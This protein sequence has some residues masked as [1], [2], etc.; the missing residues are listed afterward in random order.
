NGWGAWGTV[1]PTAIHLSTAN[2]QN[3][4]YVLGNETQIWEHNKRYQ[5]LIK[6][7]DK[8]G[9]VQTSFVVGQSSNAFRYDT[10]F[11]TTTVVVPPS[12]LN[13]YNGSTKPIPLVSGTAVDETLGSRVLNVQYSI[14]E[15]T[16]SLYWLPSASTFSSVSEQF[17]NMFFTEPNVWYSTRPALQD[18]YQ[19]S[20][21][22]Q[23]TDRAGNA[24]PLRTPNAFV[25]DVSSPTTQITNP[26]NGLHTS[27]SVMVTGTVGDNTGLAGV[28]AVELAIQ[29]DTG[30]WYSGTSKTFDATEETF[31]AAVPTDGFQT[32]FATG[33]PWVTDHVYSIK[34][35]ATDKAT[36][37]QQ[38]FT[39][40][41]STLTFTY[42]NK[43]P[44]SR[45]TFPDG[46]QVRSTISQ[47]EGTASDTKAG[48]KLVYASIGQIAGQTTSY[49]NGSGFDAATE[50]FNLATYEL[51]ASTWVYTPV[52]PYASGSRYLF[53]CFAIDK[54][55][56]PETTLSAQIAAYYDVTKPTAAITTPAHMSYRSG[57]GSESDP[58]EGSAYD[59]TAGLD[60]FVNDGVQVRLYEYGGQWWGGTTFNQADGN[61]AWRKGNA[62]TPAA[63]QYSD[64]NLTGQL[65]SGT[66]Y[67]VQV[68]AR[69]T[70]VPYNSGP[71]TNGTD[72]N[73]TLSVD[74]VSF[75]ADKIAPA[76]LLILPVPGATTYT[77]ALPTI[78]GTSNDSVSKI[79]AAGQVTVGIKEIAP[80]GNWWS[81]DSTFSATSEQFH[82]VTSLL[83]TNSTWTLT[84]PPFRHGYG[85]RVLVKASDNVVPTPNTEATASL[86]SATFVYDVEYPTATVTSPANGAVICS[87]TSV[88]GSTVEQFK[89]SGVYITMKDNV[90]GKWWDQSGSTFS[91]TDGEKIFYL[92]TP[93][94]PGI[95]TTWS[96]SVDQSKFQTG[97]GYTVSYY[98]LDQAGNQQPDASSGFTWDKTDPTSAVVEPANGAFIKQGGFV[99]VTGW[100]DD[101]NDISKVEISIQRVD[102]DKW[103][104]YQGASGDWETSAGAIYLPTPAT[105]NPPP[106][107]HRIW[108]QTAELPPDEKLLNPSDGTQFRIRVRATDKPGN[109]QQTIGD[110][111]IFRYD[112]TPPNVAIQF[113]S[114]TSQYASVP[115]LSGTAQDLFN[116]KQVEIRLKNGSNEYWKFGQGY[117]SEMDTWN[118][119]TGSSA[120]NSVVN[121]TF[122]NLPTWEQQ[123][124]VL[125]VRARDE[126]GNYTATYSTVTFYYDSEAPVVVTTTPVTGGTYK[127]MPG[128]YGTAQDGNSPRDI[129]EIRVKIY[130]VTGGATSYWNAGSSTWSVL[131]SQGWGLVDP[132]TKIAGSLWRWDLTHTNFTNDPLTWTTNTTYYILAKALDKAGNTGTE[133]ST[134]TFV[135]DNLPPGSSPTHP[136]N[137]RA[138]KPT[139]LS[140]IS[141]TAVDETSPLENVK[142]SVKDENA[143]GGAKYF[144]GTTFGSDV[145]MFWSVTELFP[146]SWTFA[147]GGL[148]FVDDHHY[149]IKSSAA[150]TIGNIETPGS[151]NRILVD[152][153]KPLSGVVDPENGVTYTPDKTIY[154][155]AADT[156]FTSGI[157]G[158][159]SGVRKTLGWHQ[160]KAQVL[161]VKYDN[162]GAWGAGPLAYGSWGGS[163]YFWDGSTWTLT[164]E[165][166]KWMDCGPIN[167]AGV[168]TYTTISNHW[169]K[170]KFY[171]VWVRAIDNAGNTQT[172]VANGPKIQI[173]AEA[174]N[175]V[176]TGLTSGQTAGFDNTVTV[177]AKDQE[178]FRATAYQGWVVFSAPGGHEIPD[179]DDTVDDIHGLPKTYKFT[180]TDAG[181]HTFTGLVRFRLIGQ[182]QLR[183]EDSV[184]SGVF[185]IQ[186]N[187]QVN[188]ATTERL[189][190]ILSSQT[191]VAG[192]APDPDGNGRDGNPT[193]KTAGNSIVTNIL[194]V[195]KYWNIN[196]GSSPVANIG[197][198]DPY[199]VDPGTY[200]LQNGSA[201]INVVMTTAGN[202]TVTASGAGT[203]NESNIVTINPKGAD[204]VLA[205][206]PGQTRVQG[207]NK[208]GGSYGPYYGK[209]GEVSQI[210]AGANMQ[211]NVYSVDEYYN[212]NAGGNKDVFFSL[213]NNYDTTVSSRT[214]VSGT[215]GM[216]LVPVTA[217]SQVVKATAAYANPQYISENFTVYPDTVT[218]HFRIQLV[219]SG[220]TP[221]AG[222]PPYEQQ[223]GGKTGLPAV[224]YTG[225]GATV[226]VRLVDRYYNLIPE[227]P[228]MPLVTLNT[229][230]PN[231]GT[232]G[233]DGKQVSLENGVGQS[234]VTFVTQNNSE[235]ATSNPARDG[236]GWQV[237]TTNNRGYW[238]DTSTNVVTWPNDVVKLRLIA[239]NQVAKEGSDPAGTGK[240]NSPNVGQAGAT[241]ALTVQAVDAYWNRNFGR[242]PAHKTKTGHQVDVE[243]NDPYAVNHATISMVDGEATFPNFA[244]RLAQDNFILWA[245]DVD[246][247]VTVASQT[248]T[249]VAVSANEAKHLQI[250]MPGE[251]AVPGKTPYGGD[252]TGGK[253]G[254]PDPVT[255]GNAI[256]SGGVEVRLT[257]DYWNPVET[258]ALPWVVLSA[259]EQPLDKYAL[260]PSS[261]QMSLAVY[262]YR[263]VF[264]STV[265]FRTAGVL[266]HRLRATGVDI[267]TYTSLNSPYFTVAPNALN[268]MQILMTGETADPGRW[269]NYAASP[270][271]L[272]G[273]YGEP[274]R[275]G[276]N[277]NGVQ[278]LWA[279][280]EYNV[281]VKGVD[282]YY[283]VVST[284]AA[285]SV[286]STDPNGTPNNV[287]PLTRS[288]INGT[289]SF[290]AKFLTAQ[291]ADGDPVQR[292][293]TATSGSLNPDSTPNMWVD[294]STSTRILVIFPGQTAAPGTSRGKTGSINDATAGED[295]AI[296]V[297]L[298]DNYFNAVGNPDSPVY[299]RLTTTDPYDAAQEDHIINMGV[300]NYEVTYTTHQ[301]IT[302]SSPGWMVSVSTYS[303]SYYVPE[304]TG[305]VKVNS[306]TN[307]GNNHYLLVLLP[308]QTYVQG[309]TSSPAGRSG[310]PDFTTLLGSTIPKAGDN[311]PVTI[312]AVDRFYN[313]VYDTDNP[314]VRVWMD[315]FLFSTFSA[316]QFS[317]T[318]GSAT[319]NVTVKRS[320]N[321]ASLS[322]AEVA[323]PEG[324]E[325]ST[326]ASSTFSVKTNAATRL[327]VLLPGET[328]IP[329][330]SS[331]KTG[332]PD[333]D[334]NNSANGDGIGGNIDDFVAGNQYIATV[335]AT[336]EFYNLVAAA[337]AKVDLT[338][339]DA[340][341]TPTNVSQ[342]LIGGV[343]TYNI[344][345]FTASTTGWRVNVSTSLGDL[346]ASTH[347]ALAVVRASTPTKLLLTVPGESPDPGDVAN[348][349]KSGSLASAPA[350]T[351]TAGNIWVATASAVDNWYNTNASATGDVW[352]ET[353]GDPYD[354]DGTTLVLVNGTTSFFIQM[355]KAGSQS[356]TVYHAGGGYSSATVTGI[357]I[358]AGTAEKV[359]VI[360]PGE[361]YRPGKTSGTGGKED[362]D[363]PSARKAGEQ[364]DVTVYATDANWNLADSDLE[365]NLSAASDPNPSGVGNLTLVDGATTYKVT[366]YKAVNYNGF[367]QQL[368][369]TVAGLADPNYTTPN[370]KVYPDTTGARKVR[371]L[372]PGESAAPGTTAGKDGSP[373][374]SATDGHFIVGIPSTITVQGTDSWGNI[375]NVSSTIALTTDDP[376]DTPV[377][378]N[379]VLT[380]GTS[381]F[382]HTFVTERTSDVDEVTSP[383]VTTITGSTNGFTTQ[384]VTIAV[385]DE[386]RDRYL[387][388]LI[389]GESPAPGT[390]VWP[391]GGKTGQP[392]GDPVTGPIDNFY[393]G[394]ITTV[395]VRTVDRYFN[396][397]EYPSLG[398]P[399]IEIRATDPY[400]TNPLVSGAPMSKGVLTSNITLR[401]KN[402]TTGWLAVASGSAGGYLFSHSTSAAIKVDAGPL[403]RLQILVPGE[404]PVQGSDTGK[405]GVSSTQI[406]GVQFNVPIGNIR[407]V[408][409]YYN[410]VSTNGNVTVTMRD[411]FGTPQSQ[412][413]SL[414]AGENASPVPI[415]LNITTDTFS[416]QELYVSGL[417]LAKSTS[418]AIPVRPNNPHQL[419]LL[420][421]GETAVPGSSTGKTGN[422]DQVAAGDDYTVTVNLVD[423]KYNKVPQPTQPTVK[424]ETV[425]LYAFP[426]L[427]ANAG[428]APGTA[429]ADFVLKFKRANSSPGWIVRA[430]TVAGSALPTVIK[431]ESP[432]VVVIATTTDR[433]QLV[434]PGETAVPGSTAGGARGIYG[435]A[436][437]T[438]AG[439]DYPV[440]VNLTDRF[441][442]IKTDYSPQVQIE[443]TDT[444]DVHPGTRTLLSGTTSY[445]VKFYT[446]PGPWTINASTTPAHI[447]PPIQNFV[448]GNVTVNPGPAAKLQVLVPGET[449][450]PGKPP[451]DSGELGGKSGAPDSDPGTGGNQ[452]FTAGTGF[453]VTVNLVDQYFNKSNT[454]NTFVKLSAN[455]PFDTIESLGSKQTGT[456]G[457]PS[458]RIT[459]TGVK[460]VTRNTTPGWQIT[461]STASGDNYAVGLSTW[462]PTQSGA[463]EK[464]LVL[465]PGEASE[466]GN[467]IG[468]S[469]D[470]PDPNLTVGS[471][472]TVTVRAVDENYNIVTTTDAV[473]AITFI[474]NADASQDDAFSQPTRPAAKPLTAGVTTFDLFLVTAENKQTVIIATAPYLSNGFSGVISP[475][476]G[477][478]ERY[479][480]LLPGETAVPGSY[481]GNARGMQGL[482]DI[483]GNNGDGAEPFISGTPFNVTLRA[484][485]PYWNKTTAIPD[486]MQLTSTDNNDSPDPRNITLTAGA[487]TVAWTM[488][489]ANTNN[490]WTMTVDDGPGAFMA[491]TSTW[492]P[493]APGTA[494]KLQIIL[495]GEVAAPGTGTGK[496]AALPTDWM[497]GVSSL[498][499]VNVVD[500]NWNVVPDA[501]LS[502]KLFNNT[503]MYASSQ[504]LSL[505]DGTTTFN[506]VLYTATA[507]STLTV[508][509]VSGQ[510]LDFPSANS[511]PFKIDHNQ[512]SRLLVLAPGESAV[513]GK[514]PYDGT[515]GKTGQPDY[516]ANPVNGVTNFPAGSTFTITVLE[517]DNYYNLV[518]DS[519][520][521]QLVTQDPFDPSPAAQPLTN[522]STT[523]IIYMHTK[524]T[525]PGWTVTVSTT[526]D[527]ATELLP[528][529]TPAIP[530]TF[531]SPKK[532]QLLLPGETA[533]PGSTAGGAK[534]KMDMPNHTYAGSRYNVQVRLTDNYYN[535]VTGVS[536][537]TVRLT[538]TDP[539]DDENAYFGGN[540]QSLTPATG[541]ATFG[542]YFNT[543]SSWTLTASDNQY[544]NLYE[545][546]TSTQ[547]FIYP[548][549]YDRMLIVLPGETYTPGK[550]TPLPLGRT[551]TPTAKTVGENINTRII[552]TDSYYNKVAT[553]S[554][555]VSVWTDDPYDTH[556]G[557]FSITNG[558]ITVSTVNLRMARSATIVSATDIDGDPTAMG[559]ANSASFFVAH[560]TASKIQLVFPGE[561]A[562]PGNADLTKGVLGSPGVAPAGENIPVEVRLC[563]NFWNLATATS[564]IRF[565]S[566][567]PSDQSTGP[568]VGIGKDPYDYNLITTSATVYFPLITL[569]DT[570]WTLTATDMDA[571][572]APFN[573]PFTEFTSQPINVI[574]GTAKKLI[575]AM[576]GESLDPGTQVGRKGTVKVSTAGIQMDIEVYVT[577]IFSNVVTVPPATSG[578]N[579]GDIRIS[580]QL[581][582]DPYYTTTGSTKAVVANTGKSVFQMTLVRAG[583][584]TIVADDITQ[585]HGLPWT[586]SPSSI[587]TVNPNTAKHLL[588]LM[589]GEVPTPGSGTPGKTANPTNRVAGATFTVTVQIV[590][591]YFNSQAVHVD[592]RIRVET[593]DLYDTHP[594][595]A[596]YVNGQSTDQFIVRLRTAGSQHT[597]WAADT[598]LDNGGVTWTTS[599]CPRSGAFTVDPS[600]AS[601]FLVLFEGESHLPGSATGKTGS[602]TNQVAGESFEVDVRLTDEQFNWM[603]SSGM[604]KVR[605]VSNDPLEEYA[606]ANPNQLS[607][608]ERIFTM[609][610]KTAQTNFSVTASTT[611]DTPSGTQ[612]IKS[613]SASGMR[614][615][616]G[617]AHHL[618][619][620]N[621]PTSSKAAGDPFN[622][623]I[624]AYDQ[625]QNLL[626]T[627]PNLYLGTIVFSAQ[628][629]A[630]QEPSLPPNYTF[631]QADAGEKM[632]DGPP[633]GNFILY[634]A[635]QCWLKAYDFT[636]NDISTE[637]VE[638]GIVYSTRPYVSIIPG[639]A[640][641]Y[642]ILSPIDM[643]DGVIDNLISVA[644]G[645]TT[646]LGKTPFIAQL[647]DQFN[648]YIS[649]AGY[650]AEFTVYNVTGAT[651]TVRWKLG[652]TYN[653]ITATTTDANGQIGSSP[654][655]YYFVST[656][657]VDQAQVR[658][659]SD[660]VIGETLPIITRGGTPSKWVLI[661]PPASATAG[662]WV[663]NQFTLERRDDFNNATTEDVSNV[664]LL[665]SSAQATAHS[666]AGR[667][668]YFTNPTSQGT[669]I[670]SLRFDI[671]TSQKK[672]SLFDEMSSVPV[673]E[674]GRV[675][676]WQVR[677]EGAPLTTTTHELLVNPGA[678]ASIGVDNP[679]RTL[680]AGKISYQGNVQTFEFE[681]W[682]G[683]RNP[684]LATETIKIVF[685]STRTTSLS[686]DA[687]GFTVSSDETTL[688]EL[689]N[690]VTTYLE[691]T[692]GTYVKQFF[693]FDT[694][695]SE[696][697][698]A[699]ASSRPIIGGHAEARSWRTADHV[700]DIQP[701]WDVDNKVAII[702]DPAVFVAGATTP[703]R[704]MQLQDRY[705]NPT[706]V[707]T[708]QEDDVGKGIK[709][710][711]KSDSSGDYKFASPSSATFVSGNGVAYLALN[712]HTTPYY[713]S[714]TLAGN[715]LHTISAPP[716]R[717][718][719]VAVQTY[720]VLAEP[721]VRIVFDNPQRKLIAGS[722]ST[723]VVGI[724]SAYIRAQTRDRFNNIAPVIDDEDIDIFS[725]S[726]K[727][728]ASV[729]PGNLSSFG[730]IYGQNALPLRFSSGTAQR[731]F[732]YL[733]EITG[734]PVLTAVHQDLVLVSTTQ[735]VVITPNQANHLTIH[736]NY[737]LASPL[738]VR[739]EG[740]IN[741][742]ARDVYENPADGGMSLGENNGF[743]Y[744]GTLQLAHSGSTSNVTMS[745]DGV[746]VSTL[747]L[748]NAATGFFT[749]RDIIQESLT[750]AATDFNK[751]TINGRTGLA[752]SDGQVVTTGLVVTPADMAPEPIGPTRPAF[753]DAIG[754]ASAL[755]QGDGNT[756]DRPN[757]VSMLRLRTEV[758]PAGV[759]SYSVWK[760]L[761]VKKTGTLPAA[762][763]TQ[764]ALWRDMGSKDGVFSINVDGNGIQAGV[765]LASSTFVNIAGVYYCDFDFTATSQTLTTTYQHFFVTVRVSTKATEGASL[766]LEIE[767]SSDFTIPAAESTA[768]IAENNFP[769]KTYNSTIIKTPA[770][771]MTKVEDIAAFYADT[772]NNEV[773][774]GM[775]AAGYLRVA[776]W[777]R[778][779]EGIL[780]KIRVTRIGTC[781]DMD[782]ANARLY[783]DGL[784]GTD[785]DA[786]H[787]FQPGADTLIESS[788]VQFSTSAAILEIQPAMKIDGTTK[789]LFIVMAVADS[790]NIGSS[791]GVRIPSRTDFI[792]TDGMMVDYLVD[793]RTQS[794]PVLSGTPPITATKDHLMVDPIPMAPAAATQGEKNV[795]VV[796][797]DM[798]SDA[799]TVILK[800]LRID[801]KNSNQVNRSEDISDIKV[802][803]DLDGDLKLNA[804]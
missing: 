271:N 198:S 627:G 535:V 549:T 741:L 778:E 668:Y 604:P 382:F 731:D 50:Y 49:F 176:V 48:V 648:N 153:H 496:T 110:P 358:T 476:A 495:P 415:T 66:T 614:V 714:D 507:A 368:S 404:T 671:G 243:S 642:L 610:A 510:V 218:S 301:F 640:N 696:S 364:F 685:E 128:I 159:G 256:A 142:V 293:L 300:A 351:Y 38:V 202:Q 85:Y 601:R 331:G 155:T 657:A 717:G 482:P 654:E 655:F 645:N 18:S 738:S 370:V 417:G 306:D 676:T 127:T 75:I 245:Y 646:N 753:K 481:T 57:M 560:S 571:N 785:G 402:T 345:F 607:N 777:T 379:V 291:N 598:N 638:N 193:P 629:F 716:A 624:R 623:G 2:L 473:V 397:V 70:A 251:T 199:D 746:G 252:P 296:K 288:L 669:H 212:L 3:W 675:G 65:Q 241:Y 88:G 25:F 678:T 641:K 393:A 508:Q 730:S 781:S 135:F 8:P 725:S 699:L 414:S 412:S 426:D 515:G 458:G 342:D 443:T 673:G 794:F 672:F 800:G 219:F 260:M 553:A 174:K 581:N 154:G 621:L 793:P 491:F 258:G 559:T 661:N 643:T 17:M 26:Q 99:Q 565:T 726:S 613:G 606:T 773:P 185:G 150:D 478:T 463:L 576:P 564:T 767:T 578:S 194:A 395:T 122:S 313:R 380:N 421:P 650:G 452:P 341:V 141:G 422:P 164:G 550:V 172:T 790:A 384:N 749:M 679:K 579:T 254:T 86:S 46:T 775:A 802:Y 494:R 763:V 649:S 709:F 516:D 165:G 262:G 594:S 467:P 269:A 589:P 303:G 413:F 326:G 588:A 462:I 762:E 702:S 289:T 500:D 145:E 149:V 173:A 752:P 184:D 735:S 766:G 381:T 230:D 392:D 129:Q 590:D 323:P 87:L 485:D 592:E 531:G 329:G 755:T 538:S 704:Q 537:P 348:S 337:S 64:V 120:T 29:V 715:H 619:F 400:V 175:F 272:A 71:T 408:D 333:S 525:S 577:D 498:V 143:A 353:T 797:L 295:Y 386:D 281:T 449:A 14:K 583:T 774:Q 242:G 229:T 505:Q 492:V 665:F 54:A 758:K 513:P 152:N 31:F 585:A 700:V 69:D 62:G 434:L 80:N 253:I 84:A 667:V 96:W 546:D 321:S 287:T 803:Y 144:N 465:A 754:V 113:P 431:S 567:D 527:S 460:L 620:Y 687:F 557:T 471:T 662:A 309:K 603:T 718:W 383:I 552:I 77:N 791:L 511:A 63:W 468:K 21:R 315:D 118:V 338:F 518:D 224:Q 274:D 658:I 308:G 563:D 354:V 625:F 355:V 501:S 528:Y 58:I 618:E 547:V 111:V 270:N 720:T 16:T 493:V 171:C 574:A 170:G 663:S 617:V 30:T 530:I 41:V 626:S 708:G 223:Q 521:V 722:T 82:A 20:V 42:D 524:N 336:D 248:I 532:L 512:S 151:G 361:N 104:K 733:D 302:A 263:A 727:G 411:P 352:F 526:N 34:S 551:D 469:D 555:L 339:T 472:F 611:D 265:I 119:A 43:E 615:W 795:P 215:T 584:H 435:T 477:S 522:G 109:I 162:G 378:R 390:G 596:L 285:I 456:G 756:V 140:V 376:N 647:S 286:L 192:D 346:L 464:L 706:P 788:E 362:P 631:V 264:N 134:K 190:V 459:F 514:G 233:F 488:K 33:I 273:K 5:V 305:P 311:F 131:E 748:T 61:L 52:I 701:T 582:T 105:L 523:F 15:S 319:I 59:K 217:G 474:G 257:D 429:S 487:T 222:K 697:Y 139:E 332:V 56:N 480:I 78:S 757:P 461:A 19:Y 299:L 586:S 156:G 312:L 240:D 410:S 653:L 499:V 692:T 39:T 743:C 51:G 425:N 600:S 365:V 556:P 340:H 801:R 372:F 147:P 427:P 799:H 236:K 745:G 732:F 506:F 519:A 297:R 157:D 126:A 713:M 371:L 203:S 466:E 780:S 436:L 35:R 183:V 475:K 637:R 167:E 398:G 81:G 123:T 688:P 36:N 541:L 768:R 356:L 419:Q 703:A 479:Q 10:Q 67:L 220:E 90:T 334:G 442:N 318:Q 798:Y 440:T 734:R 447:S 593:S 406:A 343:T 470:T 47:V 277:Q 213:P 347:S 366:L 605:L 169:I 403:D 693:Y 280:D 787:L 294:A 651:G 107:S 786:A 160:G 632:F 9:N 580:V 457:D 367:D 723:Y 385:D 136:A 804:T 575:T 548:G 724:S 6:A 103:W 444:Y 115:V 691:I 751:P 178:G 684:T 616:S 114:N 225:L 543:S 520:R 200:T 186:S 179:D 181:I 570:G 12:T 587:V 719:G 542:V 782:V 439:Y 639:E 707:I 660:T 195:D 180:A 710:D 744:S 489:T 76:S 83:A 539:W 79:T 680:E 320:T 188:P 117:L 314:Q 416:P 189:L 736:H 509:W 330:S 137:D 266:N 681:L 569:T 284:D 304:A 328:A 93:Q 792:L 561:T 683:L 424:V 486:N 138:Y 208:V 206:L 682:D 742:V 783:Y 490:G 396:L 534:G 771:V 22:M 359:L 441:Y 769:M 7:T 60:S 232:F 388:I 428:L 32:W 721:P 784:D 13:Y 529:T 686:N 72:S 168:W 37:V 133:T 216:I 517:V 666:N 779:F 633:E 761:R 712:Q 796:R 349:G 112:V 504:T 298:T 317:L 211:I 747:T 591:D 146:S 125:N 27:S 644:A 407:A 568:W 221:V 536:M 622:G 73:F 630:G 689:T 445:V 750:L 705:S 503:D 695:S 438:S 540:P 292:S 391:T 612:G 250:L 432:A 357:P 28:S 369:A 11:P 377:T 545:D 572:P 389:Q 573:S 760:G 44:D 418:S 91:R 772:K 279:G 451:Y 399:T 204:R 106:G 234:T 98:A 694:H 401:T 201:T 261:K 599:M 307:P 728:K 652:S 350:G 228:S 94:S 373:L 74:S 45:V 237:T 740:T 659:A 533:V 363:Q 276:D 163:D 437:S 776:V 325:Y 420:C 739:N 690:Y 634:K 102:D 310:P 453:T 670:T 423:T 108:V 55:D 322:A 316:T 595:T 161:I 207:K 4:S 765:P 187:V 450:V 268:R 247:P 454:E 210:F 455:D 698:G 238:N 677:V 554:A 335:K 249:G 448:S 205:V 282:S 387:Q 231:D 116:T 344:R 737:S 374:G 729:T 656:K 53:R 130:K 764:L 360:L 100:A 484:V 1:T 226:T 609:I 101:A 759:S 324:I 327:Q 483:D 602:I 239:P 196:P 158:T 497:A 89:M 674:D 502:V 562:Q 209:S 275:D 375:L 244:P 40:G 148:T 544:T 166:E 95:W 259:P 433:L 283:N 23:A 409:Q 711:L 267:T 664:S 191:Y 132:K 558:E 405:I 214:L 430:S 68:R 608:G 566:T 227:G 24:E 197:T 770:P 182:R 235:C 394:Q 97:R 121:W 92:A 597:L 246:D 124:Y 635:T 628:S 255:A 278:S 290:W 446:A 177:E 636:Y 789:Y